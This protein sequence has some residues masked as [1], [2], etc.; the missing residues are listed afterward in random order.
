MVEADGDYMSG[1]PERA[2]QE[3]LGS[4]APE[5]DTPSQDNEWTIAGIDL[6]LTPLQYHYLS[7]LKRLIAIKNNYQTDPNYEAPMMAAINKAIYSTL[8]DSIE[9]NVGEGAKELLNKEQHVN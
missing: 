6:D 1:Q 2:D 3:I 5:L 4:D 9:A 7:F 8:L